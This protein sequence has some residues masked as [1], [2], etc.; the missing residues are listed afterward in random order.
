MELGEKLEKAVVREVKEETNLDVDVVRL[1]D[2]VDNIVIDANRKLRFHF[3][4]LD[5]LTKLKGGALQPS[6]D[7]VDT[8]W[9][10]LDES[11][12]YDLTKTFREFLKR[13]KE[14]LKKIT[15]SP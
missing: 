3:V 5:F 11:E 8:K 13:N 14:E 7:V 6:S 4:I 10:R 15:Q 9:V 2:A 1:I 12:D